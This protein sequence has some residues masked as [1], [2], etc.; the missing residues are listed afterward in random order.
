[1][2]HFLPHAVCA[3]F[4]WRTGFWSACCFRNCWSVFLS[5][6]LLAERR[7]GNQC[8]PRSCL[9]MCCCCALSAFL[10]C[11]QCS[12]CALSVLLL[13]SQCFLAVLSVL[14]LCSQCAVAVLSVCCCCALSAL[15]VLSVCCCCAVAVLLLCLH[16]VPAVRSRRASVLSS[17]T[18]CTFH[19]GKCQ[20]HH[21]QRLRQSCQL[22]CCR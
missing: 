9:S 20:I 13:C 6:A 21:I 15:A 5:E 1:M 3:G 19:S 8:L 17:A 18:Q 10:L 2:S 11:S 4:S 22:R 14:L 16:I 7:T 12:C